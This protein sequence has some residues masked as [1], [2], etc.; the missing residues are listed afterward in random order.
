[1]AAD[2]VQTFCTSSRRPETGR[3]LRRR[4]QRTAARRDAGGGTL[5]APRRHSWKREGR[6]CRRPQSCWSGRCYP[7][8]DR[9]GLSDPVQLPTPGRS[10]CGGPVDGCGYCAS[11]GGAPAPGWPRTPSPTTRASRADPRRRPPAWVA[12][13]KAVL[14]RRAPAA[15][16]SPMGGSRATGRRTS[17]SGTYFRLRSI[18][19]RE[20]PKPLRS[21]PRTPAI[22]EL[23]NIT[24]IAEFPFARVSV[25]KARDAVTRTTSRKTPVTRR[26][27]MIRPRARA[28]FFSDSCMFGLPVDRGP[29]AARIATAAMMKPSSELEVPVNEEYI[30]WRT[31]TARS[32]ISIGP[33]ERAHQII[34]SKPEPTK[35]S[36]GT[37][38]WLRSIHLRKRTTPPIHNR[39]KPASEAP[40]RRCL[41]RRKSGEPCPAQ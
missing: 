40:V 6:A 27:M 21:K 4:G 25:A 39:E 37:N 7:A 36:T 35:K 31:G 15:A 34:S 17:V 16:R 29:K 32:E 2:P 9:C 22:D 33:L 24:R 3:S 26:E 1:M 13:V 12:N 10:A 8:A 38:Q 28:N 23:A 5:T 18:T 41:D 19:A 11:G 30:C 20:S 14:T